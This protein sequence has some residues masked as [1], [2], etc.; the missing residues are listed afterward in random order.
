[1]NYIKLF[2][3]TK[4]TKNQCHHKHFFKELSLLLEKCL[5]TDDSDVILQARG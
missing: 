3:A 1:M 5:Y 4:I 2:V